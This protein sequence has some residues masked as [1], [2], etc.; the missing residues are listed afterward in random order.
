MSAT[1]QHTKLGVVV[2]SYN[3]RYSGGWFTLRFFQL[4]L[5]FFCL[6]V[7]AHSNLAS[8]SC[9]QNFYIATSYIFLISSHSLPINFKTCFTLKKK[10]K[11]QSTV[12][13]NFPET[14]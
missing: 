6:F 9:T 2:Y 3:P 4:F 11:N 10:K 1:I 5:W 7:F 13:F 8:I 12:L 14:K